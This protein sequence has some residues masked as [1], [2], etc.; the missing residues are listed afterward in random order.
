MIFSRLYLELVCKVEHYSVKLDTLHQHMTGQ[1]KYNNPKKL[2]MCKH[3]N[4][5]PH[6]IFSEVEMCLKF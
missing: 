4:I 2:R 3:K 6:K 1:R 5:Y